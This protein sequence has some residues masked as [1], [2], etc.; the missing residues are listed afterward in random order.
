[1]VPVQ[2]QTH[3]STEHKGPGSK[4][5][6][7]ALMHALYINSYRYAHLIFDKRVKICLKNP[8]QEIVLTGKIG[9]VPME[10]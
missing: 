2:R 8:I 5:T 6:Q 10:E 4:L 1:M 9:Q 3:R 7:Y